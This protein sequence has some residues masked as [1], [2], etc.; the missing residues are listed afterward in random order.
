MDT[1]QHYLTDI[2][3][4][5]GFLDYDIETKADV[6]DDGD[7]FVG[8]LT[9]IT[10]TGTTRH[11]RPLHREVLHLISKTPP[12]EQIQKGIPQPMF[13]REIY[14]Y[15]TVLPA[16]VRFQQEN[17]LSEADAFLA[18]PK[19][20]ACEAN[21]EKRTYILI[22]EDLRMKNYKMW[23]KEQ[24][25]GLEQQLLVMRE[26]G[27]FHAVSFAMKDQRPHDFDE[28]KR[29]RDPQFEYEMVKGPIA[30]FIAANVEM[31][32]KTVHDPQ[33][34]RI[35]EKFQT[36]YED[37]AK[38]YIWGA[39]SDD[40]AIVTHSDCWTNNIMFQYDDVSFR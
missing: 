28:F 26:L 35:M 2:A 32:T 22:M 8:V 19:V 1:I 10:I 3:V 27:R 16:F 15:S 9:A 18:F 30:A 12:S 20:Y 14:I 21:E 5:E 36:T 40:F 25:I 24:T 6:T 11:S 34:K 38:D 39:S 37:M 23:P 13:S 31:T 33:H 7:N 17:G 4:R 29:L